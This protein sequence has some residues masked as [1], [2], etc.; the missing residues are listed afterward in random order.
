MAGGLWRR[1]LIRSTGGWIGEKGRRQE[2]EVCLAAC[3]DAARQEQ[4][5]QRLS[6]NFLLEPSLLSERLLIY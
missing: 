2:F 3:K 6:S 4:R 1:E 5:K